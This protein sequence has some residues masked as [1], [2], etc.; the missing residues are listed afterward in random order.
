MVQS[1]AATVD[2]YIKEADAKRKP[3]LTRMRKIAREVLAD[4]DEVMDYGMATYKR[5]G[6][7]VTAFANQKGY[8]AFYAGIGA[9]GRHKKELAGI[10]CG[11]GCIRYKKIDQIDFDVVRSLFEDI[12][13]HKM[14]GK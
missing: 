8:L 2:A 13:K 14:A 10:D 12:R 1:K 7:M 9:M 3:A 5:D 4:C 6:E 11:K